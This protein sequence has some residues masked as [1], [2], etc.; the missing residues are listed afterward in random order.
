[1]M[2][3]WDVYLPITGIAHVSVEAE[4]QQEAIDAAFQSDE[5]TAESIDT[6]DVH[7]HVTRA[8][9]YH[10]MLNYAYAQEARGKR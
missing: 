9:V 6:W 8:N 7:R 1:M 10:G 2:K 5:V 3:R 4:T